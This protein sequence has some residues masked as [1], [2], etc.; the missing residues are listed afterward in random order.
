[1]TSAKLSIKS[2]RA[3][4]F[5]VGNPVNCIIFRPYLICLFPADRSTPCRRFPQGGLRQQRHWPVLLDPA[6]VPRAH[7]LGL[8]L[9]KPRRSYTIADGCHNR[10]NLLRQAA[11]SAHRSLAAR[12]CGAQS[13]LSLALADDH[14]AVSIK[15][16][17]YDRS[18][19]HR[20]IVL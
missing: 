20:R 17:G 4:C 6:P 11:A 15:G 18:R 8:F 5:L 9:T 14:I 19:R 16:A 3:T 7:R 1:M 12:P 2:P 10:L 13:R